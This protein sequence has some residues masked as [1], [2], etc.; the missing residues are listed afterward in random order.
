MI[1][2]N[3]RCAVLLELQEVRENDANRDHVSCC[4][5]VRNCGARTKENM[6]ISD[7][8]ENR[9]SGLGYKEAFFDDR[10]LI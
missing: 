8:L 10:A 4:Q 5:R 3:G 7:D 9:S 1:C 2:F 6:L